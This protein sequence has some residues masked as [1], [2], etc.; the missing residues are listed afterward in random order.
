VESIDSK[1]S[2]K[3]NEGK[4]HIGL[5]IPLVVFVLCFLLSF[6]INI[7]QRRLIQSKNRRAC[8]Q[9]EAPKNA[10]AREGFGKHLT[11]LSHL[12]FHCFNMIQNT[13][14]KIICMQDALNS[15]LFRI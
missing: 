4:V 15:I 7:Y 9:S 10:K 14:R 5:L 12:S 8:H 2:D 1:N 6:G 13:L 3:P 11:N